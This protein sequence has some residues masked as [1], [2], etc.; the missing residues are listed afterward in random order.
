[1]LS[2]E[3]RTKSK[4]VERSLGEIGARLEPFRG[5]DVPPTSQHLPTDVATAAPHHHVPGLC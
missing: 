1:M 3:C 2:L 5:D 4:E